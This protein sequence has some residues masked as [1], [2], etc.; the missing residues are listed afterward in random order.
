MPQ[1]NFMPAKRTAGIAAVLEKHHID[2]RALAHVTRE[3][4][5]EMVGAGTS[6]GEN[7]LQK[8]GLRLRLTKLTTS[9]GR[10]ADQ[11]EVEELSLFAPF[12][13]Y[14]RYVSLCCTICRFV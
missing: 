3:E 5:R 13:R 6:F 11:V 8:T 10:D 2:G 14:D 9:L 4:L 1:H 7:Q 12:H